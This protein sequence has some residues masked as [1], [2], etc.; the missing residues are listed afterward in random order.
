MYPIS[1]PSPAMRLQ[2][3]G[4]S[5][6]IKAHTNSNRP[7]GR[8]TVFTARCTIVQSAVL[9]LP[10]VGLSVPPSV[11]PLSV[12]L[13]DQDHIGWKSWK[14]IARTISTTYLLFVAQRPST[15]LQGTWINFG[16]TR[17]GV[18]KSGMLEHKSDNSLSLKRVMIE[19]KLL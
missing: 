5:I 15:L 19:E 11:R 9:R 2:C 3:T 17:G 18:G 12:M 1:G 10:V 6:K 13:V 14:L 8:Q 7:N 4:W 16:E